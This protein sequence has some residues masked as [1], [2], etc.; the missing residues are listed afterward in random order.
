[1]LSGRLRAEDVAARADGS[2]LR[3]IEKGSLSLAD[4]ALGL[5]PRRESLEL[6]LYRAGTPMTAPRYLA[7]CAALGAAGS[8]ISW[9]PR[10]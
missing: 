6:M 2:I 4:R 1:M 10:G 9:V 5:L 3:S 7:L 8:L